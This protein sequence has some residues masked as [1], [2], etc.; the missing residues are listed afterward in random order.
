MLLSHFISLFVALVGSIVAIKFIV[1]PTS[2]FADVLFTL[3]PVTGIFTVILQ[4]AD[5]L[6]SSVVVAVMVAF[7]TAT[8]VTN[9]FSS[10][11]ATASLLLVHIS[12]LFSAFSG[13]MVGTN[14][15]VPLG[16]TV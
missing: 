10:I 5:K 16:V 13:V 15:S 11:V 3:I 14:C 12:F 6:L 9:P 2:T 8:A 1:F 4:V 7:P